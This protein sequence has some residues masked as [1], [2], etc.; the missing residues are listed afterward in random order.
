MCGANEQAPG[1]KYSMGFVCM[2]VLKGL[3]G[4]VVIVSDLI[5]TRW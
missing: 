5:R 3:L 2:D 1:E 4:G